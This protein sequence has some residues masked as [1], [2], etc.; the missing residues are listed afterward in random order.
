[1]R[2]GLAIGG[3]SAY[4]RRDFDHEEKLVTT[5]GC[6]AGRPRSGRPSDLAGEGLTP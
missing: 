1:V 4:D 2:S 5:R 6:L 3:L